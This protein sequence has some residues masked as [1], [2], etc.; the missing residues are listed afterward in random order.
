MVNLRVNKAQTCL[1]HPFITINWGHCANIFYLWAA[2]MNW[3]KA[4]KKI[5]ADSNEHVC[6][7]IKY[8]ISTEEWLSEP[9]YTVW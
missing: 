1:L 6:G 3:L 2:G 5:K 7:L 8:N 4:V 9:A